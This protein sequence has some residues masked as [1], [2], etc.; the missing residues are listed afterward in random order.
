[1]NFPAVG[2]PSIFLVMTG[3]GLISA[4]SIKGLVVTKGNV[5]FAAANTE[6]RIT[7]ASELHLYRTRSNSRFLQAS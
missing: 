2:G 7:S 6:P 4:G 3:E 1:M 5:L